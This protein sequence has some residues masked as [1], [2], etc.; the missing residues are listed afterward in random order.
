M[1]KP[2][3][4]RKSGLS[5]VMTIRN[6]LCAKGT[7]RALASIILTVLSAGAGAA[8]TLAG[9][10]IANTATVSYELEGTPVTQDSNTVTIS[11]AEILDV[12]VTLV[13]PQQSVSP[14]DTDQALVYTITNTGNGQ[15]A[16]TFSVDNAL[17]GDDFDPIA[18]TPNV[19]FDSD[20]SGDFSAGDTPYVP[21]SGDPDLAP[22][23]SVTLIVVND[24]P[25]GL[26]NGDR[27][28]SALTAV[29]ATGSGTPG[30]L[31]AGAGAGGVDAVAGASGATATAVGEYL[32]SDVALVLNKSALVT[33]PFG[34]AQPVPGATIRYTVTAEVT[35][36]GTAV[37]VVVED[38][39]PA[40][41][42]YVPG[43]LTLNGA[44]LSDAGDGD[45]GE[46]AVVPAPI[47]RVVL[48]DLVAADGVQTITFDVLID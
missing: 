31:F 35:G 20:G 24:I 8:G 47:V 43:S 14:G 38:L 27:G 3:C 41:T 48:G 42:S 37:A 36:T 30:T 5:S 28:T 4:A 33:D 44:G 25:T 19:Y 40:N 26:S 9:T 32:V 7:S 22:D 29:A 16:F 17:G 2:G 13:S 46:Y 39:I 21:G 23:A 18:A 6:G 11:V 10:D 1:V 15:E 12:T 34:G 45:A